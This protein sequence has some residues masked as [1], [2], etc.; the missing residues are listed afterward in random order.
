MQIGPQE[1]DLIQYIG[2]ARLNKKV[3]ERVKSGVVIFCLW[4]DAFE[5][6]AARARSKRFYQLNLHY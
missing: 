6:I 5:I 1:E 2:K 4:Q 3:P